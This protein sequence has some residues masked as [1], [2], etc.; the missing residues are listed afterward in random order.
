MDHGAATDG[1]TAL[2]RPADRKS[3]QLFVKLP[4]SKNVQLTDAFE[5]AKRSNGDQISSQ[6]QKKQKNKR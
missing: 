5:L 6:N 3:L 4:D 2:A 1:P